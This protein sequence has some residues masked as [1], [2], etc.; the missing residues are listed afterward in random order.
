[1]YANKMKGT[2]PICRVYGDENVRK[3]K[4]LHHYG[5]RLRLQEASLRQYLRGYYDRRYGSLQE[6][7]GL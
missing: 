4:V 1:M 5:D 6:R 2:R 3:A 7:D